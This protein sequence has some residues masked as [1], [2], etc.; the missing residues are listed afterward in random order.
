VLAS[1]MSRQAGDRPVTLATPFQNTVPNLGAK[2]GLRERGAGASDRQEQSCRSTRERDGRRHP[3]YRK[4]GALRGASS[5]REPRPVR[6]VGRGLLPCRR[7]HRRQR[8]SFGAEEGNAVGMRIQKHMHPTREP[9]CFSRSG[10]ASFTRSK[11][12]C[13]S[14]ATQLR[15][16]K[17]TKVARSIRYRGRANLRKREE[18]TPGSERTDVARLAAGHRFR[19][20]AA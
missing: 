17:P 14:I 5:E 4:G 16:R 13:T 8:M 7:A 10:D 1:R 12:P 2:C 3:G 11:D 20:E 9:Q 18:P 6:R 15:W 19:K